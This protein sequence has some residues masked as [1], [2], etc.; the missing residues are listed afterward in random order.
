MKT[1]FITIISKKIV[2]NYNYD[3]NEIQILKYGL[4]VIYLSV[5]KLIIILL[6]A[7]IMNIFKESIIT[8]LFFSIIRYFAQGLHMDKSYKC[9]FLSIISFVLIPYMLKFVSLNNT[10]IPFLLI[11]CFLSIT[12]YAPAD[13][14]KKPIINKRKRLKGKFFSILVTII[15]TFLI[16]ILDNNMSNLIILSLI[17]EALLISP[18][19]YKLFKLPYNNYRDFIEKERRSQI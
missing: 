2:D 14:Y 4:S 3:E 6:F 16:L 9:Y 15:Y 10:I 1:K 18:F 7:S 19:I 12:L 17:I 8:L 11:F 5:T 13:T